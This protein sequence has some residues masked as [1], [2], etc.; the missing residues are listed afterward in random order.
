MYYPVAY[1]TLSGDDARFLEDF[2][3]LHDLTYRDV[4]AP[5]FTMVFGCSDVPEDIYLSHVERVTRSSRR[6]G[7]CC[8]Y[9]KLGSDD[10]SDT[11]YLFLVPDEGHSHVSLL[12]DRLYTGPLAPYLRLDIPYTP[13]IAI[14]TLADRGESMRL[15]DG[16][17][18]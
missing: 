8:R 5:Y 7:F 17:N 10:A 12:H 18:G 13:H 1:P 11:S 6:I 15:C 2:R 3:H 9:A 16:L 4:I 14:A